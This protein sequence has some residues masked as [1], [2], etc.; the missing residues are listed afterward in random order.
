MLGLV[1]GV[2]VSGYHEGEEAGVGG[3]VDFDV[4]VLEGD[5]R[6]GKLN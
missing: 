2:A 1:V 3:D 6:D 5:R 4:G